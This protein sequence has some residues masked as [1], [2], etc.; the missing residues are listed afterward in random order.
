MSKQ[1]FIAKW[2]SFWILEPN[3]QSLDEAFEKELD[4]LIGSKEL[5]SDKILNVWNNITFNGN[6]EMDEVRFQ[7]AVREIGLEIILDLLAYQ[8]EIINSPIRFNGVHNNN[9]MLVF[10]SYGIESKEPF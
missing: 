10:K 7:Q 2:S 8:E 4:Y 5:S 3:R 1:K 6:I 9:I